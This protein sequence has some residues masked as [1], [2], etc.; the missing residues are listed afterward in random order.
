MRVSCAICADFQ[1]SEVYRKI[2]TA[3]GWTL[4]SRITG[5]LRDVIM[6][7]IM[8]AGPL[9]D[10]FTVAFRLPNHFRAIFA[11]GAFND[12]FVPNYASALELE[13][14]K[15][16]RTFAG[17]VFSLML[18]IQIII[19]VAAFLAMPWVVRTLAPGFSTNPESFTLAVSLTRITFPYLLFIALLTVLGGILAA[20]GRFAAFN[21][22]PV[23]LSLS[24]I[25]A[26][27]V[28]WLF[29]NAAYAAAW[30]VSISGVL[31]F[32]MVWGAAAKAGIAP[33][34][35]WPQLDKAMRRFFRT[36]LPSVV[37]SAGTQIA[38]FADTIIGT[39]LP[40][41][42]LSALYYADRLFQL[43][44]GVIAIAVGTVLLPEMTRLVAGGRNDDAHRAQNRAIAFAL[45]LTAP[46]FVAFLV[47]PD[48]IV[49][50]AFM[51]GKFGAEAVSLSASVLAAYGFGLPAIVLIRSAVASF[52][53]R[54]D[55]VTPLIASMT[56]VAVNVALKFVLMEPFGIAGLA[57]ATAI[58]AW[59]NLAI[60]TFLAC[61]RGW[62]EPSK[63]LARIILVVAA[64]SL[65]LAIFAFFGR[66][67]VAALIASLPRWHKEIELIAL[68]LAGTI[69]YG[70]AL[71]SGLKM[72][73]IRLSRK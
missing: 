62:M 40:A 38:L 22:A 44:L 53:S 36:L 52:R 55:M 1:E 65:L 2:L 25:A 19:L 10:A 68:G 71:L 37:G 61:R 18:A 16:A 21:A 11:E 46:F 4:V 8:G 51:R 60:L 28:A 42:S 30:G 33:T 72:F 12:A 14:G 26:L 58:G 73:G 57:F 24:M 27:G 49:A 45:A 6:A 63:T 17:R 56:A 66:T 41:A 50:A 48:M 67:P 59:L 13:G 9:T 54:L 34:L 29:P 43:P 32:L 70:A 23:L 31:Q 7:A 64:S 20:H 35:V 47:I 39:L 3:G 15:A 5:F 69:L